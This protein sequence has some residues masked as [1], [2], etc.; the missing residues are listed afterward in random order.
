MGHA[1]MVGGSDEFGRVRMINDVRR[2]VQ[3]VKN[4]EREKD[5]KGWEN[6]LGKFFKGVKSA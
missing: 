5:D 2:Y 4:E 3:R 1:S 6:W